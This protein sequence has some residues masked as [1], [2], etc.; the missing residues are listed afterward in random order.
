MISERKFAEKFTSFW[1]DAL[2]RGATVSRYINLQQTRFSAPLQSETQ[3]NRRALVNELGFWLF[4]DR[5]Q[6]GK[7]IA[8]LPDDIRTAEIGVTV[9]KAL[10]AEPALRYVGEYISPSS[11]EVEEAI[12]L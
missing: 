4:V 8:A 10:A 9:A 12:T 7:V 1:N 11:A 6:G 2:P 3:P 5:I